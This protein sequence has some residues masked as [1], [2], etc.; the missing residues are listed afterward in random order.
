MPI[1]RA[2]STRTLCPTNPE[3]PGDEGCPLYRGALAVNPT[4]GDTFA[5]TVDIDD[6]DQGLWQ[7]QC[8]LSGSLCTNASIV[9]GTQWNTSAAHG[10]PA[11]TGARRP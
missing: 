4:N 1:S 10:R 8:V 6:Q 2:A 9:F 5:W 7:D 11:P 3:I